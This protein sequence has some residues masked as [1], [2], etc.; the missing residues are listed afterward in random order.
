V[1]PRRAAASRPGP[2]PAVAV[3]V[4]QSLYQH[5]LLSTAQVRAI[6]APDATPRHA[7]A[8]LADLERR[9][10]A[11]HARGRHGL[12]LWHLTHRG[13]HAAEASGELDV[14]RRLLSPERAA[15]PL[16]AHTLAVNEVGIAFM[17]AARERGDEFGA[18][19]WRHEV[20][21][22]A[23]PARGRRGV[24][25]VIVDAL[26]TY[27][28]TEGDGLSLQYRFVELDRAT[29]P[30]DRLA[31]KLTR[32][33]RLGGHVPKGAREPGWRSHYPTFPALL[34]VLAD[35]PRRLLERRRDAA[36]ALCQADLEFERS[37]ELSVSIC[38]LD[39]LTERGPFAPIFARASDLEPAFN[40]LG[41]PV[42][43]ATSGRER[44]GA[45]RW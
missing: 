11:R 39:D 15:G 35:R 18:L 6:H 44:Q 22:V 26:L 25:L 34:V 13:A 20:A 3:A 2:L 28:L 36:I 12:K 1:S 43:E 4:L 7:Q 40:W 23:G 27:L 14:P 19:S 29:L 31:A 32:Y 37:A 17:R 16:Q 33:A 5:R 9:G 41:E 30:L 21:H 24:E 42:A 38:L 8:L 10:L 45:R